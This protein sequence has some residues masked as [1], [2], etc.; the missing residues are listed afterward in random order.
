VKIHFNVHDRTK[1]R[2][3]AFVEYETHRGAAMARRRFFCEGALLW[4]TLQPNVDWA[5]SELL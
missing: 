1:N 3:Y 4:D 2:G 5:E